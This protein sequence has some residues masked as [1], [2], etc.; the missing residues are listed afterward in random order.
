MQQKFLILVVDDIRMN[1]MVLTH[2]LSRAGYDSIEAASADE[3]L[4]LLQ[5][6]TPDLIL[7]DVMMPGVSGFELCRTLKEAEATREIPIIFLTALDD[8]ANKV[9]GLELGAVDFITKPFEPAEIVARV[10]TQ[11][12]MYRM[13]C[14]IRGNNERMARDL[15]TARRVQLNFLPAR[16][17]AVAPGISYDYAYEPCDELGGDFFNVFAVGP[18]RVLVYMSDVSGHGVASALMTIFTDTFFRTHARADSR[19]GELLEG[20]NR[21]FFREELADKHIVV[22]LAILDLEEDHL[23]WSSAGQNVPPILYTPDSAEFLEM[24]SFPIGLID[25]VVYEERTSPLP[26]HVSLLLYS[27]GL[28]ELTTPQG[29]P[30]LNEGALLQLVREERRREQSELLDAILTRVRSHCPDGDYADDLTLFA[31]TREATP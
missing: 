17:R 22:F 27:D 4:E 18:N 23:L 1:R 26:P 25:D 19:P 8:A 10:H 24:H 3:A 9:K 14:T 13:Y 6:E 20:F 7:L 12:T 15:A 5:R 30:I 2:H 28:T 31:V 11:A 16:G 21:Q 29:E